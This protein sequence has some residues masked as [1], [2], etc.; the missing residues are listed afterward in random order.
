MSYSA[1]HLSHFL[2][3]IIYTL[4]SAFTLVLIVLSG[5]GF[6][7]QFNMVFDLAV[8]FRLQYLYLSILP[9][10]YFALIRSRIWLIISLIC[11]LLNLSEILPW[12]FPAGQTA[13]AATGQTIRLF[14]FNVKYANKRY[15]TA[16]AY[17]RQEQPTVAAFMEIL[18]PWNQELQTLQ[19]ILPYHVSAED[20]NIEVYSAFPLD[21]VMLQAYGHKRGLVSADMQI[22]NQLVKLIANHAESQTFSG[23]TGFKFRNQHLIEGIGDYVQSLNTP[24]IVMGDLN[25]TMWSVYYKE[26][27]RRSRLHNAQIGFGI[28]P[29]AAR[30]PKPL[31][32][33]YRPWTRRKHWLGVPVDHCLVSPE[34]K[35]TQFRTGRDIASDHLPIIV[36]AIVP[37]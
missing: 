37:Q 23:E 11:V 24:V 22:G 2:K 34:I 26:M 4:L 7:G 1:K 10:L 31:L 25:I 20:F 12:Y 15:A 14:S 3:Q 36:D 17:V 28:T 27:I 6:L 18:P 16:I 35:I 8:N 5:V 21:N 33:F 13:T 19:D 30:P 9:L 29:T 32:K